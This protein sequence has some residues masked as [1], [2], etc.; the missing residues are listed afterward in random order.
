MVSWAFGCGSYHYTIFKCADCTYMCQFFHAASWQAATLSPYS[1][2]TRSAFQHQHTGTNGHSSPEH[3]F[4]RFYTTSTTHLHALNCLCVSLSG[5]VF[6]SAMATCVPDLYAFSSAQGVV[7]QRTGFVT[8]AAPPKIR[9]ITSD[10]D[11]TLLN[12]KQELTPAVKA[13]IKQASAA[14]VPVSGNL[15]CCLYVIV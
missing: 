9:M 14:G 2:C 7:R 13:S 6:A 3:P 1:I 5:H 12:S 10:V 4:F 11:G 8:H 15:D